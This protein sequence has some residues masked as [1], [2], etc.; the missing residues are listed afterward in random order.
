[1]DYWFSVPEVAML[2]AELESK[3]AA[4]YKQLQEIAGDATIADMCA[5]FAANEQE[6]QAKFLAIAE[7][8]RTPECERCYSVDIGGM[9]KA[10]M[11]DVATFFD[12]D[13]SAAQTPATVSECLALAARVEATAIAVYAKMAEQHTAQFS[14]VLSEVVEEE[15]EHLRMIRHVQER[16]K[17]PAT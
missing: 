9:L 4:F 13:A 6:H 5:F 10:S 15:R 2:A 16:L 14:L 7:A 8:H 1:V 12:K 17:P 3:G 11:L